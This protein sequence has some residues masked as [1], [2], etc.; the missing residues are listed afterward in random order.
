MSRNSTSANRVVSPA[1]GLALEEVTASFERFCLLAGLDTLSRMME[2]DATALCSPRHNRGAERQAHRWGR[3][4][5]RLGFHGG[6]IEVVRPRVR[7]RDGKEIVLPSWER[8]QAEDW[9]GP[10]A[11]NL[12]LLGLSL[13]H[14]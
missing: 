2:R 6:R 3:T 4:R 1:L 7:G 5:G 12:M 9:L 8:A 13:I 10:W 11:V 14:I